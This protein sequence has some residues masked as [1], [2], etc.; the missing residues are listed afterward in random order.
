MNVLWDIHVC[1]LYRMTGDDE[2][3]NFDLEF[4]YETKDAMVFPAGK[5][6]RHHGGK[7]LCQRISTSTTETDN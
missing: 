6:H 2:M 7:T 1:I 3:C 4:K 5:T